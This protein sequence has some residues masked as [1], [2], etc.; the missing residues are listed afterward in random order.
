MR[1]SLESFLH[2]LG[3]LGWSPLQ[4]KVHGRQGPSAQSGGCKPEPRPPHSPAR[5]SSFLG[6]EPSG[7][8]SLAAH[9]TLSPSF[10]CGSLRS[11]RLLRRAA[12]FFGSWRSA[13]QRTPH[14]T[15]RSSRSS[16]AVQTACPRRSRR[17]CFLSRCLSAGTRAY[18]LA[19]G[20]P[21]TSE[22]TKKARTLSAFL[23]HKPLEQGVLVP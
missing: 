4:P 6:L 15:R 11:S 18:S 2:V 12:S 14:T 8:R 23:K 16:R 21:W 1:T 13:L 10:H 3:V 22:G 17:C 5:C 19:S 20:V 9:V 7:P